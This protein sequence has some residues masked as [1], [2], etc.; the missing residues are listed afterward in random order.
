MCTSGVCSPQGR[1]RCVWTR[2]GTAWRARVGSDF[3]PSFLHRL[4]PKQRAMAAAAS[5][6]PPAPRGSPD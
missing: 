4:P 5:G 2:G 6:H 1:S 3:E